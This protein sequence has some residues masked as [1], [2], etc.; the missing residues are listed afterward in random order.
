MLI[1]INKKISTKIDF[2][3]DFP[4]IGRLKENLKQYYEIGQTTDLH[5]LN[6]GMVLAS[7]SE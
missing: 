6:S 1:S 5:S 2:D 3:K 4:R 7:W